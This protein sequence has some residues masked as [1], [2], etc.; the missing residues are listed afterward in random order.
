MGREMPT[1]V[2]FMACYDPL[3]GHVGLRNRKL[4]EDGENYL[5]E[6]G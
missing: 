1:S 4:L 6:K 5:I 3:G 2:K